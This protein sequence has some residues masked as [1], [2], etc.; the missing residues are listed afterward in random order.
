M[1]ASVIETKLYVEAGAK[2]GAALA[3]ESGTVRKVLRRVRAVLKHGH[4]RI[5][6]VGAGGV[7]KTTL[8]RFL[9]GNLED[10]DA[11]LPYDESITH[12][13]YALRSD[14][15][16]SLVVVPGQLKD[17]VGAA[18]PSPQAS[19]TKRRPK[20]LSRPDEWKKVLEPLGA[21]KV[22][23]IV[24][25]VSWGYHSFS[26]LA[27]H[28]L[29]VYR[30]AYQGL[31]DAERQA[32]DASGRRMDKDEILKHYV[33]E[34]RA[35][36][37][38]IIEYMKPFL[39][40]SPGL[41]W[42]VTLVAKQDLWW[43]KREHVQAYYKGKSSAYAEHIEEIVHE[44]GERNFQHEYLSAALV[45]KNFWDGGTP[46]TLLTPTA[47]GYDQAHRSV[48]LRRLFATIEALSKSKSR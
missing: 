19:A 34:R 42:M 35:A 31:S 7:G 8:G 18:P 10:E 38:T 1:L 25:V 32:L 39:V 26:Q 45:W 13:K 23:G 12:E 27:Y 11:E 48:N 40:G 5:G 47:A 3:K 9:A 22:Q 6:I 36:E 28:E 16:S 2:V 24:N 17:D 37:L 30:T 4:V 15:W 21:G 20:K 29:G 41:R 44:R 46:P 43:S 14:L 33:D